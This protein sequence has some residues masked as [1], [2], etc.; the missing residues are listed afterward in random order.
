MKSAI[1]YIVSKKAIKLVFAY[2]PPIIR[3]G[4][5]RNRNESPFKENIYAESVY[6]YKWIILCNTGSQDGRSITL[7]VRLDAFNYTAASPGVRFSG[8]TPYTAYTRAWTFFFPRERS[9]YPIFLELSRTRYHA[10]HLTSE[11]SPIVRRENMKFRAGRSNFSISP[12]S[13]PLL[14]C[15]PCPWYT[16]PPPVPLVE[17]WTK[18]TQ[19]A[20]GRRDWKRA[21][22]VNAAKATIIVRDI[23]NFSSLAAGRLRFRENCSPF[24]SPLSFTPERVFICFNVGFRGSELARADCQFA[25]AERTRYPAAS[26]M[27]PLGIAR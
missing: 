17:L 26:R 3:R 20:G 25:H 16:F 19:R 2:L 23:E 14:C 27:Q 18:C 8:L 5:N 15:P 6:K 10:I 13:P 4:L 12:R 1:S 21:S 11:L 22:A 7:A 9:F 24:I